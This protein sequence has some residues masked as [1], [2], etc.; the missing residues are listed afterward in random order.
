MVPTCSLTDVFQSTLPRRK[1]LYAY[2]H[3]FF[4][5]N[6]NPRS[7][8]GSDILNNAITIIM[9]PFQSTLP[10]RERLVV[11]DLLFLVYLFQSTLPRRERLI[12]QST[13]KANRYFNPRSHEGSDGG[14]GTGTKL[15]EISI[16][17]PTKGATYSRNLHSRTDTDFNPCSHEGSDV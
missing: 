10:R 15:Y 5:Q 11:F 12:A 14:N 2:V 7:H 6:F 9:S 13:K 17:A 1:R 8:E 4:I 16:H 3:R